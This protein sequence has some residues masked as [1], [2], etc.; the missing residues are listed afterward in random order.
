MDMSK[1]FVK[2][3][4]SVG[5]CPNDRS[6][7][8]PENPFRECEK[9]K[10]DFAFPDLFE[11]NLQEDLEGTSQSQGNRLPRED[12]LTVPEGRALSPG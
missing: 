3:V 10:Q 8:G 9:Q 1:N 4:I 5:I 6:R 11:F 7:K 2:Y 12:H